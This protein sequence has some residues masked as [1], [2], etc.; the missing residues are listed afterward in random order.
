MENFDRQMAYMMAKHK[1][2][3]LKRF[4]VHGIIY[5]IVNIILIVLKV[6]RNLNN[7]EIFN[8]AFFDLS[9][10]STAIIWGVFL[11]MHAFSVFGPSFI[12]GHDWEEAKLK[13]YMKEEEKNKTY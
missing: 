10:F 13:K 11:A 12:L 4:Y 3:K 1:A 6:T 9:T 5:L 2:E 7:G 8:E